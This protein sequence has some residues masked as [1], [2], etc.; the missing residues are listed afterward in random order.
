MCNMLMNF[1]N[2]SM[3][4]C[5]AFIH[6]DVIVAGCTCCISFFTCL[7]IISRAP[8]TNKVTNES[9]LVWAWWVMISCSFTFGTI[10]WA[11]LC[12]SIISQHETINTSFASATWYACFAW[13]KRNQCT[14]HHPSKINQCILYSMPNCHLSWFDGQWPHVAISIFGGFKEA[15]QI[16]CACIRACFASSTE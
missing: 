4:I 14:F 1:G 12:A 5:M 7:A 9:I 10:W 11:S 16:R 13:P 8:S 6:L 3:V 2:W 15:I